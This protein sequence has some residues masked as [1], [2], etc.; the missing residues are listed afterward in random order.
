MSE[1]KYSVSGIEQSIKKYIYGQ[2][3]IFVQ[4]MVCKQ[5]TARELKILSDMQ[6]HNLIIF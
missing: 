4:T 1:R 3:F 2:I 5:L 6:S